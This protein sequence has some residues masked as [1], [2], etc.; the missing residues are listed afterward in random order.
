MLETVQRY[1]LHAQATTRLA[2]LKKLH[3]ADIREVLSKV[4]KNIFHV[5]TVGHIILR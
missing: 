4:N 3:N 2:T 5:C 1:I